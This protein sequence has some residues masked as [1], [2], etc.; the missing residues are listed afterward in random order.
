MS[1]LM[2]FQLDMTL[3]HICLVDYSILIYW[4]SPFPILGMCSVFCHFFFFFRKNNPV[5]KVNSVDSDQTRVVQ[6]LIWVYTVCLGPKNGTLG[7]KY[8]S[9]FRENRCPP[10]PKPVYGGNFN[11]E[12]VTLKIRSSP[13][14]NKL[15]TLSDLYRLANLVTFHPMVHN[16]QTNTFWLNFGGLSL[17]VTLKIR[18]RSPKPIQLFIMSKCYI[19]ANLVKIRQLVHEILCTQAPFGSNLAV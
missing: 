13:K 9:V 1:W 7:T 14:S 3:T 10:P 4:M 18:S 17:T 5:S 6:H 11:H 15:L 19:H 2:D 16:M 12:A 8:S